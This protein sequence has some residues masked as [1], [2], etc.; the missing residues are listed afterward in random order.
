MQHQ[1]GIHV[2]MPPHAAAIPNSLKHA[3]V[4]LDAS[5]CSETSMGGVSCHGAS[6]L[7]V[8]STTSTELHGT[9]HHLL[10]SMLQWGAPTGGNH[11]GVALP[12]DLMMDAHSPAASSLLQFRMPCGQ[13]A[14]VSQS[15]CIS[16][17]PFE[18]D[19]DFMSLWTASCIDDS[20]VPSS[21]AAASKSMSATRP[22]NGH[23]KNF[24]SL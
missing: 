6:L 13:A 14:L 15:Q 10:S 7:S 17:T 9:Q 24:K 8:A 3:A 18:S 20:L 19:A 4:G 12:S 2:P 22:S 11:N 1:F 21:S 23:V 16:Q 5:V